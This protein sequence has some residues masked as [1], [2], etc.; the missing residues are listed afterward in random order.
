MTQVGKRQ[1]TAAL[2]KLAHLGTRPVK[3]YR[4]KGAASRPRPF[5]LPYAVAVSSMGK[6]VAG[7]EYGAAIPSK[8]ARIVR[9]SRLTNASMKCNRR[10]SHAKNLLLI[11]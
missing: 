11:S 8:C 4:K 10:S 1:K 7:S 2:Q 5:R 3:K 9:S 6:I